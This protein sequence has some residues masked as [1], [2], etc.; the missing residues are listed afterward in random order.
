MKKSILLIVLLSFVFAS[1]SIYQSIVNVS[2]L[3]FKLGTVANVRLA[4]IQLSGKNKLSD[5]SPFDAIK[6]TSAITKGSLPISFVLNI[7]VKNPNDGT[8]GY[9]STTASLVSLPYRLYV[10]EKEI[11]TGDIS[12]PVT[13]L[14]TGEATVIPLS[15][16]FDLYK[17]IKDHG[18][19][20]L[21]NLA[22]NISGTG[23]G[24]SRL[25]VVTK[26]TVNTVIGN[27]TYPGELTIVDKEFRDK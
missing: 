11:L 9:S 18:F 27:I 12:A 16:N 17:N 2:R 1:C 23:N 8:G 7:D 4:D 13:I 25:S 22:L 15:I 14:G 3:K 10:D 19:E 24:N 26:P 21:V 5:F 6:L 20:S